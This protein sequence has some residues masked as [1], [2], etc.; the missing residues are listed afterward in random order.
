ME[1]LEEIKTQYLCPHCKKGWETEQLARECAKYPYEIL[2]A[3][4]ILNYPEY[5]Y[6][7]VFNVHSADDWAGFNADAN[8]EYCIALGYNPKDFFSHNS[9]CMPGMICGGKE[10]H[11]KMLCTQEKIDE[12]VK[13][14]QKKLKAALKVQVA[15]TKM[16]ERRNARE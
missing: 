9:I 5:R 16:W 3:G 13:Q 11:D 4:D 2:Q 7:K 10:K 6:G 15:V 1:Y 12:L 14:L 8:K